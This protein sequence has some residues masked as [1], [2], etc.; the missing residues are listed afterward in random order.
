M[1]EWK[2]VE[3]P[4]FTVPLEQSIQVL[5]IKITEVAGREPTPGDVLRIGIPL[6]I[7]D[8]PE[9]YDLELEA[10]K[11]VAMLARRTNRAVEGTLDGMT[12]NDMMNCF[13]AFARFFIPGL[14]TRR[15]E[16]PAD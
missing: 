9:A 15:V 6:R 12:T 11:A 8:L 5:G 13:Y 4:A 10:A 14:S 7:P 16:Q 3:N 1:P 2:P